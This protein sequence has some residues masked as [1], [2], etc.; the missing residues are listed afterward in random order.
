MKNFYVQIHN[1]QLK[2]PKVPKSPRFRRALLGIF[3][4][5][6]TFSNKLIDDIKLDYIFKQ[7]DVISCFPYNLLDGNC[8]NIDFDS[9]AT[10]GIAFSYAN[11][12]RGKVLNYRQ[13]IEDSAR[14][15]E[16][17]CDCK[18]SSFCNPTLGHVVTGDTQFVEN[19]KLRRLLN[20]GLDFRIPQH[21]DTKKA[22]IG[23]KDSIK[24]YIANI[25]KKAKV[26]LTVFDEW[27]DKVMTKVESSLK[28]VSTTLVGNAS[29][30]LN[31]FRDSEVTSSLE[32]LHKNF[33]LVPT[34]KCGCNVSIVC[35]RFYLQSIENELA[36]NF[37]EIDSNLDDILTKHKEFYKELNIKFND[38]NK[39]LPLLY[40]TA[41]QHKIPT[42]FRYISST[43]NSSVK[44]ICV[45]LKHIFKC[46][47]KQTMT[48]CRYYDGKHGYKIRS[49][50]IIENNVPVREAIFR[51]NNLPNNVNNVSSFDFD[52]LYTSLPHSEIKATLAKIINNAF[53]YCG[54]EFIRVSYFKAYFSDS[55][56]RNS[57]HDIFNRA[58]VIK[59]LNFLVD[60]S[61]ILYKGKVFRQHT[62]IPMGIDPAPFMA[63]LFL[64]YYENTYITNLVDS[65]KIKEAGVLKY[66]FRYL[67][68]LFTIDDN[69]YFELVINNIYPKELVLSATNLNP[70]HCEF[71]D[72]DIL[73]LDGKIHT[74]VFD[75]RRTFP[76]N[77]INF[78]DMK[79]SN[80]PSKPSY[81]IYYSQIL[82]V[83]RICSH[84]E[85]FV[86]ELERLTLAFLMKGFKKELLLNIF[87]RFIMEY[88]KEW[89][90]FG[91]EIPVPNCLK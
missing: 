21:R 75:K 68:D 43:L 5:S 71:L 22:V 29:E 58:D 51:R 47:Q 32:E 81:G 31:I 10:P 42:K 16:L 35:K 20:K 19:I 33:V 24:K 11:S 4:K 15:D 65:G 69:S 38:K 45:V 49:C 28:N 46:I 40:A 6:G 66:T 90:K 73:I 57:N 76:F 79:F 88:T 54:K 77:V 9:V 60:N 83:L 8:K 37:E 17:V 36:N 27:Y 13:V 25:S 7:E 50:F 34:D 30:F 3:G 14:S 56:S 87:N 52:T 67:D 53:D 12:I 85:Y 55:D 64:H 61:Y 39:K 1:S 41:K 18:N 80:V 26:A 44:Q 62:G 84:L 86:T 63:N 48:R 74:K 59:L 78:P 23:I 70:T 89:G 2:K 91:F 72:L 82:R